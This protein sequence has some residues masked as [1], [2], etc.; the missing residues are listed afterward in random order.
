NSDHGYATFIP[1]PAGLADRI[2]A[3]A[4]HSLAH[5]SSDGRVYAWGGN[6]WGQCGFG[7]G[8]TVLQPVPRVM[9]DPNSGFT[10]IAAGA[11]FSFMIHGRTN[12]V[13]GTGDNQAGELA[14]NDPNPRYFPILTG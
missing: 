4:Y 2:A 9:A 10:D 12:E 3:G 8:Q 5:C 6:N 7:S 1:F 13:F 14:T 11:F